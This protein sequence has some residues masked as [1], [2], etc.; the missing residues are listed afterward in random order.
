MISLFP[1]EAV[2]AN[3][4]GERG[5]VRGTAGGELKG[6][7]N[8]QGAGV[9]GRTTGTWLKIGFRVASGLSAEGWCCLTSSGLAA[10]WGWALIFSW[11]KLG[12]QVAEP[13]GCISSTETHRELLTERDIPNWSE[14]SRG[15]QTLLRD[16]QWKC[17]RNG[18]DWQQSKFWF[19][20]RE[21]NSAGGALSISILGGSII[22]LMLEAF[23]DWSFQ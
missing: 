14:F 16:S 10:K 21:S 19:N 15:L 8:A 18:H 20:I 3:W 23:N 13:Q 7:V 1:I 11:Q 22:E 4:G 17:K 6:L 5:Q 9:C 12:F 2:E